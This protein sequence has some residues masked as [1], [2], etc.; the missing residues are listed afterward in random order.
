MQA[1]DGLHFGGLYHLAGGIPGGTSDKKN[2]HANTG[3]GGSILG[4]GRLLRV[5]NG[6][7]LQYSCL[8]N[9]VD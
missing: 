7:M 5:G 9:S 4:L 3:D 1:T 8:E 6:N 2:P